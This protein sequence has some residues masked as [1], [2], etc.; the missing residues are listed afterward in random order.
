MT[1]GGRKREGLKRF[2]FWTIVVLLTLI[3]VLLFIAY[4]FSK[5]LIQSFQSKGEA[6][7]LEKLCPFFLRN[8]IIII[9]C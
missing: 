1:E 5:M 4:P 2:N 3:F 8:G 7:Y 9:R 6:F